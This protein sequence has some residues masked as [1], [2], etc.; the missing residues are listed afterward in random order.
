MRALRR[1]FRICDKD[2]DGLLNDQELMDFQVRALCVL[3]QVVMFVF[4][5]NALE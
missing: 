2:K 5:R 1:I 3:S 4:R